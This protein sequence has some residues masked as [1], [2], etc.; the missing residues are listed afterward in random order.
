MISS[1]LLDLNLSN[2]FFSL[3]EKRRGL[4]KNNVQNDFFLYKT[5]TISTVIAKLSYKIGA[6]NDVILGSHGRG[7]WSLEPGD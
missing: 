3:Y 6:T 7:P 1:T 2:D 5:N 4:Q